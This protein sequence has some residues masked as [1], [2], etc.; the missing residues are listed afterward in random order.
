[1]LH[2]VLWTTN[3]DLVRSCLAHSFVQAL[4]DGSL[5]A[6]LFR[7]FVA[8]DTFFLRAFQKAYALALAR[9]EDAEMAAVFFDLIAGVIEELKI[10]RAYAA[11]L[12][13]DL[14]S[15][16]PNPACR[17][18]TDF[19]LRTAWHASLAE[20]VAAMTPCM[21]LYAYLG[22]ELARTV[23]PHHPYRRWI[24]A[25][26]GEE[27]QRLAERLEALLDR[28]GADRDAVRDCYRYALEC[29]LYFFRAAV[30]A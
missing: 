17:S 27:F 1:M 21:Q 15:V 22:V 6:N 24:E 7:G 10:H 8:Q 12:G 29:E 28:L 20:V 25:Y 16:V 26:S 19:L 5:N 18:Y 14:E 11:E 3:L 9:S 23:G 4:G 2:D 13:I 30:T